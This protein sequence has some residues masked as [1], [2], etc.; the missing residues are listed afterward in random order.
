M[1]ALEH[2]FLSDA[3]HNADTSVIEIPRTNNRRAT[4]AEL[5]DMRMRINYGKGVVVGCVAA[6]M[7]AGR[8]FDDAWELCLQIKPTIYPACI[9]ETWP[10]KAH[11]EEACK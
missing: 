10:T 11:Y 2:R 9:P 3:L 8:Y 7:A 1:I 6:I 5:E 4:K